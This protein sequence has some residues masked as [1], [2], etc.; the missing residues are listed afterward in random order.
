MTF[1][2]IS[3]HQIFM[4]NLS[5]FH[6]H[7]PFS[8]HNPKTQMLPKSLSPIS[9]SLPIQDTHFFPPSSIQFSSPKFSPS[10][11]PFD[12]LSKE[13]TLNS[14]KELHTQMIKMPKNGNFTTMDGSMVRYYLEFGDFV[15]AIKVFFV[16]FARN[17]VLWNSFLAEFETF[18]GD[19][20]EIIVVF[21]ELCSKGVEFDSKALTFVLKICLSLRDLWVGL[22]IHACL[23]K[24]GFHFD[25]HLSCALIN[26][27]EKCWSIDKANQVFH[28]TL[29]QEDFLWNTI[30][31]AN[32][33]SER[34]EKALE[35]FCRMQRASAKITIGTIVKML[36]ACGKLRAINEG[37]QIH[38]YALRFGLLSNTLVCNS[39][40]SMYS[41]NS[42][43]KQAR[44]VFD[45]M[46]DRNLSSW[47]SIISSY[48][49]DGCSNYALDNI[50]KEMESS[51]IKP[52]IITWNSVLSG[53][54]LRGSFEMVLTSFRSLRSAGFKPDSCSV[55]SALQAIIELG[56]F[57]LGKE[58]HGYIMRSNLN[59][60]VYVCTSLV[61]M[62]VKNDCLDKAKAVF[63]HAKNKNN[64]AWNSLISGYS[65][66]G[67]FGD[68]TKLLSQM[69][70]EGTT[71]DLVTWNGLVSGY[72]M[73]GHIE[74]ASAIIAR[75]KSS[76]ITPNVVSWTA[77]ISGCSQNEKY[78]DALKIFSQMQEENVKPNSTTVCSL[79]CACAG[80]SLLKKGE[81]IHCFSMKL[82]FVDDIYIATA[83]ID[84]YCKAGKLK[85][86]H[87]VFNKIQQKTLPCWN[88]MM[89]GYAIHGYGEEVTILYE[90]MCEKCIRPDAITFTALL[91]GCKNSGLV[92]E[93]WKYFDSMQEDYNIVPTI[94][95]YCCMV[96]LLGK[97]GFLDEAWDFIK[98]MRI[99]PDASIWGALL[100]SCRIHKN[101]QLAEI[102]ARMLF[103]MEPYN[104]ANY[105]LMMNLYSSLNRWDD[106]E[107]LQRLMT[108]LEMKSPPVWSWTQVNQTIHVF[109]TEGKPHT[110]EG[111][112]YFEL[113]QLI[114]EIRKLGYVPD[115]NCVCQNI[116]DNE[117]EKVLMSHTEKLAMAYGVM[118]VK[119]G[120]PIRIVKN[121]RICHDCH[122]VAKYISLAR[123]REI[124][125]RDGGRFHHFKNGTCACNDRW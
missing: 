45:S 49:V 23:I 24:K 108:G 28:E 35:L 81:E 44:S 113:Y 69:V 93:G 87:N 58:I 124:F 75:I 32:L 65:F 47:N 73:R 114:S 29:Y 86:A 43:H 112:I 104:S 5:P 46:E 116:D 74:E 30:V 11:H 98:T 110:E 88:C 54:L 123:K 99:K 33:R 19:P 111:R 122:M 115:L 42:R 96:D 9:I 50:V 119:G 80:S 91:S 72:S 18:G 109:S 85:V 17:Y 25:V 94:E 67:M 13:R 3:N 79:L 8:L 26:F 76:G 34:W 21:N 61:D 39:I 22:E 89:M 77:L 63:N 1:C 53:Y 78:I 64:Y 71:P 103:K 12:V 56:L 100:A 7:N 20:F 60:D 59:Y 51:N 10:F 62:Y 92:E 95:H 83:L 125:V 118:K 4:N 48:A 37:K 101:I 38:G 66:K 90:K 70:E 31:M 52:D 15:S 6:H 117:K 107:R 97:F 40:I 105:V 2:I 120:S 41:R 121:T 84:M 82:G 57:K 27:Y 16:G 36:Q 106:V 68:A 55:T 102:A 14:V